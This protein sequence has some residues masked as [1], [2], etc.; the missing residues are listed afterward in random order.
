MIKQNLHTHSTY[1]DGK[2]PLEE[3]VNKAITKRFTI[4]GFSE[5][6]Y[7]PGDDCCMSP[8]SCKAYIK[9]VKQLKKKYKNQIEIF[10]GLE[11][12]MRYRDPHPE[13][14]DYIIGSKHF[15][16]HDG[17][18]LSVDYDRETSLQMIHEWYGDDFI[19]FAKDYYTGICGMKDWQEVDIVGH[20]DLLM[21]YNE[22]ESFFSF[23]DERY[24]K[25]ACDAIDALSQK[26]FE[27]NTGAIARGYRKTPYPEKHLLQYMKEKG[28]K[29]CLNSD[30]HNAEYL[31]CAFSLSKEIIEDMQ[32]SLPLQPGNDSVE[33]TE[34]LF[35][36]YVIARKI[37]NLERTA[38]LKA[39]S[40]HF[41]TKLYT[42]NPTPEL[43]QI[44]NMGSVDYQ[45]QMPYVFKNSATNLNIS[46]RSIRSGIPLRCF[47]IMGCGG[48]LLS[49]Y[50]GDF[51][52]HFVP[53][54]DLVLFESQE[55]FLNKCDYYLK[56]DN[57]RRQ[58]AA[59]GYGKVKEFHT[60][61]VRLKE[62]F[63]VVFS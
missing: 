46:L 42:P 34:W 15:L 31:D 48:F 60:Y 2:N 49:N 37:A 44:H 11:Q 55:D 57:E 23:T 59:N 28:I 5:H 17:N 25:M 39:V 56:H 40:E 50:Q 1:V 14:Y 43:S 54:E 63:E 61:E 8:E 38:L 33:S 12:D 10:L 35:A 22:D 13:V 4:L 16:E 45:H 27:V 29:I 52:E 9:E 19:L 58:I 47:D 53:G 3:M 7:I 6:A 62:I 18:F 26:I 36:H 21:K 41:N 30:C 32:H 24:I 51:Y 20:L